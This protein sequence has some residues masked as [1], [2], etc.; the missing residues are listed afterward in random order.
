MFVSVAA[1]CSK[2]ASNAQEP[3]SKPIAAPVTREPASDEAKAKSYTATQD[4]RMMIGKMGREAAGR[5]K[6]GITAEPLFDALEAK[7]NIKLAERKQFM[8]AAVRAAFC[9]GGTTDATTASQPINVAMCEYA[10]DASAQASLEMMN[11]NFPIANTRREAHHA[12]VMTVT[13]NPDDARFAA[14][15]KVFESL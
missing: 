7:A 14:A 4:M 8:G 9:A 10:D 2:P 6:V 1:A 13:G 11:A 3:A 15:F 12:A 5:P